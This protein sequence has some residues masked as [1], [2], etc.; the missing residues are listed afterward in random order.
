MCGI[1]T[2]L[3]TT[4]FISSRPEPKFLQFELTN[5]Q[6]QL[7]IF[8][9]SLFPSFQITRD[10]NDWIILGFAVSEKLSE[11]FSLQ[12]V[13]GKYS[14]GLARSCSFHELGFLSPFFF[15]R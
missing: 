10:G 2:Q 5:I 4:C 15:L 14:L 9:N 3:S 11:E 13:N 8:V 6:V 7:I 12:Q 1:A